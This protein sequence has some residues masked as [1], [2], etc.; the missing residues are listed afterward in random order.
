MKKFD[1]CLAVY[2]EKWISVEADNAEEAKEK[3]EEDQRN[4]FSLCNHCSKEFELSEGQG[5]AIVVEEP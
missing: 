4:S 5:T 3:A 1:V 2:A